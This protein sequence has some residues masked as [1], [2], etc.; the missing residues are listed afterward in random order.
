MSSVINPFNGS[1]DEYQEYLAD[2]ERKMM[3]EQGPQEMPEDFQL[4]ASFPSKEYI[5]QRL[6][7]QLDPNFQKTMEVVAKVLERNGV[8]QATLDWQRKYHEK[9][10]ESSDHEKR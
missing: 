3:E 2:L 10:K 4:N 5:L 8:V 9:I 1:D 7:E 6:E